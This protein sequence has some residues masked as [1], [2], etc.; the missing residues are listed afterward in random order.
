MMRDHVANETGSQI[1]GYKTR[2]AA[3][4][5]VPLR[6]MQMRSAQIVLLLL[7][8]SSCVHRRAFA[9]DHLKNLSITSD[10]KIGLGSEPPIPLGQSNRITRDRH[11]EE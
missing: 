10:Q 6:G 8:L 11:G 9:T 4:S 1:G 7:P 3:R 2:S 5:P